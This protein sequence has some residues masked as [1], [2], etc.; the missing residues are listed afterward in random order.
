MLT[1]TNFDDSEC[2]EQYE[3]DRE[4]PYEVPQDPLRAG[5]AADPPI[6]DPRLYFLDVFDI[7]SRRFKLQWRHLLDTI[8]HLIHASVSVYCVSQPSL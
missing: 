5:R 4:N 1:D 3:Y 6:L 7:Q 8:S 2:I